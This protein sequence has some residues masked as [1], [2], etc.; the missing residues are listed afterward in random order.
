MRLCGPQN[1]SRHGDERKNVISVK[2]QMPV[3][4]PVASQFTDELFRSQ[5]HDHE[6]AEV[7]N[8]YTVV[9]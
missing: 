9:N 5:F 1:Q 2:Y 6:V 3:T 7:Q 8:L 4:Q